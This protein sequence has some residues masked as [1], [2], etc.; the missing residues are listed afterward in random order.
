VNNGDSD[1]VLDHDY[2]GIQEFNNP[3]PR[4]WLATFYGAIL[5]APLYFGYYH[6]GGPGIDPHY[7]VDQEVGEIKARQTALLKKSGGPN[8]QTLQAIFLDSKRRSAGNGIFTEKCAVCH[9]ADGGGIIGPNLT[10]KYWIHGDGSL[11]AILKVVSEGVADKGMP[12]WG[13]MLKPDEILSVVAF[14][15][16]MQ[17]TKPANPKA[18]QG[19]EVNAGT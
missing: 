14:V 4:W 15:K 19:S 18:P 12:P 17:G 2:D 16:S 13:L 5:F 8:E 10:D 11:T 7:A 9:G 6:L 3:L 1:E